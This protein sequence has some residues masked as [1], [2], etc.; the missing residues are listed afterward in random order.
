[1]ESVSQILA[2]KSPRRKKVKTVSL[3]VPNTNSKSSRKNGVIQRS[4]SSPNENFFLHYYHDLQPMVEV[5]KLKSKKRLFPEPPCA[6]S[7]SVAELIRLLKAS[8]SRPRARSVNQTSTSF[9]G[10]TWREARAAWETLRAKHQAKATKEAN[11]REQRRL[12][13]RA[14]EKRAAKKRGNEKQ[15]DKNM[16]KYEEYNEPIFNIITVLKMLRILQ[17]FAIL[18]KR[19]EKRQTKAQA[20]VAPLFVDELD[21]SLSGVLRSYSPVKS[22]KR[23]SNLKQSLD[24]KKT[25]NRPSFIEKWLSDKKAAK[26]QKDFR[27]KVAKCESIV[28]KQ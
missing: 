26:R 17:G 28:K 14:I 1:M 27:A 5:S 10:R 2:K 4:Q 9:N 3:T 15:Y 24:S 23:K 21:L 25:P 7:E 16:K 20:K 12:I 13:L 18:Q 8:D 6:K 11:K 22:D 19:E